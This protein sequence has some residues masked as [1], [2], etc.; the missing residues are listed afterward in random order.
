MTNYRHFQ[1]WI[2]KI[3][4]S[5]WQYFIV[6]NYSWILMEGMYL[7]NLVFLALCT[8][9]STIA[10]YIVLGWGKMDKSVW[11][12][13]EYKVIFLNPIG[14][15]FQ[16]W[17]YKIGLPVLVV[18]PWI[19]IRVT[20]EDT[21]CWTTHENSSLFLVIR[22][23]IIISILVSRTVYYNRRLKSMII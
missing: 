9:T 21:L 10:L 11:D 7:H 15:Q 16:I 12:Y 19:I 6:A 20:I 17:L 23:P 13:L 1:T 8:D 22:I 5:L 2:C 18:V 3:I 4:T 14:S